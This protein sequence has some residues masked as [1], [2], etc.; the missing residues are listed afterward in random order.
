MELPI[1]AKVLVAILLFTGRNYVKAFL[2]WIR[3]QFVEDD[4]VVR[5]GTVLKTKQGRTI[6]VN[7]DIPREVLESMTKDL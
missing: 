2:D 3:Q 5:K 1:W 6:T 4:G 7:A